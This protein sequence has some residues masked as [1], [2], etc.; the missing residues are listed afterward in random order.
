MCGP[1]PACM[2]S[3]S[4]LKSKVYNQFVGARERTVDVY[5]SD[6]G[7]LDGPGEGSQLQILSADERRRADNFRFERDRRMFIAC[8][9]TLRKLLAERMDVAPESLEFQYGPQGKPSVSGADVSF[10]A[11]HS[12]QWFACAIS[13]GGDLG[14]DIEQVHPLDEMTTMARHFFAPAEVD[15]LLSIPERHRVQSFFE[16]WTRKEAVIK[17]TGEGVSRALDSFE[18][19]FGPGVSPYLVRLDGAQNPGWPMCAFKPADGYVAALTAPEMFGEVRVSH[20]A[21]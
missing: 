1:V 14:M 16:C 6:M 3:V 8:R 19:T 12:G 18:V 15:R 17:A 21:R 20:L 10:N 11:S 4:G 13:S 9:A 2:A 7:V 5:F